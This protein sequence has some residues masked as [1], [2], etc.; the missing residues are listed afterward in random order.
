MAGAVPKRKVAGFMRWTQWLLNGPLA[1]DE[2]VFVNI[3]ET[4]I[5][6]QLQPRRGYVIRTE[7]K[8]NHECY[9]RV[10][11]RD[12]RGQATLVGCVVS[13]PELQSKMPQFIFT[14]DKLISAADK[15][16]LRSLAAPVRW[17]MG[18]KRMGHS[19][20]P[21]NIVHSL[22]QSNQNRKTTC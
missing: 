18:T 3:D 9:A 10:P 22:S 20:C 4:P 7:T 5:F 13:V 16:K 1:G 17:V 11:L 21:E 8:R 6:R 14:N 15:A 12:R 2:V 19:H